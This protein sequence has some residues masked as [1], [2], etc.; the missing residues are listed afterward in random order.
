MGALVYC[1]VEMLLRKSFR[2][3]DRRTALGVLALWLVPKAEKKWP[4][5]QKFY[6]L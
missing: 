5:L 4:K 3:F 1:A 2:I 6:S